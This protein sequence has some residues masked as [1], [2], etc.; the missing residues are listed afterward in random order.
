MANPFAEML[1]APET[2]APA[3]AAPA[4]NPFQT[5]L[6]QSTVAP[7][8]YTAV[9]PTDNARESAQE[10]GQSYAKATFAPRK[11]GEQAALTGAKEANQA[12]FQG[13]LDK[14]QPGE[15]FSNVKDSL[16][17]DPNIGISMSDNDKDIRQKFQEAYPGGEIQRV[18]SPD[19][20]PTLIY[21]KSEG[22]PWHE[23]TANAGT[24]IAAA[25]DPRVTLGAIAGVATGGSSIPVMAAGQFAAGAAGSLLKDA[26]QKSQGYE[27][28]LGAG[29]MAENAGI[30]GALQAGGALIPEAYGLAKDFVTGAKSFS[31]PNF[32]ANRFRAQGT[33]FGANFQTAAT[34]EGL[35][36]PNIGQSSDSVDTRSKYGQTIPRT[37]AREAI[38]VQNK[39]VQNWLQAKVDQNLPMTSEQLERLQQ[40]QRDELTDQLHAAGGI[41]AGADLADA[42]VATQEGIT[43]YAN[44]SKLAL[45]QKIQTVENMAKSDEVHFNAVPLKTIGNKFESGTFASGQE[46]Q[47]VT[48]SAPS[49]KAQLL[50]DKISRLDSDMR[51]TSFG[52]SIP[53]DSA[54]PSVT[55]QSALRQLTDIRDQAQM[56]M[57]SGNAH[58]AA[59]GSAIYNQTGKMLAEP[60]GG[61]PELTKAI[62]DVASLQA[63]RDG[64][65]ALFRGKLTNPNAEGFQLAIAQPRN[66]KQLTFL[67][68]NS[69]PHFATVQ[70]AFRGS[71]LDKPEAIISTLD[72]Y[73]G[74]QGTLD[75]LMPRAEQD[76]WRSYAQGVDALNKS[77]VT[78][79]LPN[80]NEITGPV[81]SIWG[82]GGVDGSE[83]DRIVNASRIDSGVA[84]KWDSPAAQSF[85]YGIYKNILDQSSEVS[86]RAGGNKVLNTSKAMSM[87]KQVLDQADTRLE[88]V[89][90]PADIK[91]L[92]NFQTYLSMLDATSASGQL[93][94]GARVAKL[95]SLLKLVEDPKGYA[96]TLAAG[97]N[98]D[99]LARIFSLPASNTLI[100]KGLAEG[101]TPRGLSMFAGAMTAASR[102]G[103]VSDPSAEE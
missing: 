16:G 39:G 37:P 44:S 7:K 97:F 82:P 95:F 9:S 41:H 74:N 79:M 21:K 67:K 71:L 85:K 73:R 48:L 26:F 34:E 10:T 77:S 43:N 90:S 87:V 89:L 27:S 65:I 60:I 23:L 1:S 38:A 35:P 18:Q 49:G 93:Q 19:G 17:L 51:N 68:E 80:Y 13:I 94:Q 47:G 56:L 2:P 75:L 58:D 29:G 70:D 30:S 63:E 36:P 40:L 32:V 100:T 24:A 52:K 78:R 62:Q 102:R 12:H 11:A 50:I 3:P 69:P 66:I 57:A 33:G 64:N 54:A 101:P 22:E 42:G 103:G 53:P 6:D 28:T 92:E 31:L 15:K 20:S 46:G 84:E 91:S 72:R 45:N 99:R 25:T 86:G 81:K 8:S 4:G 76:A 88:A 61:T 55:T 59:Y 5:M 14:Q 96:L 98:N 83:L